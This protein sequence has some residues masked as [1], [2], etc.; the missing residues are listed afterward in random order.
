MVESSLKKVENPQGKSEVGQACYFFVCLLSPR[1]SDGTVEDMRKGGRW[2]KPPIQPTFFLRI[3][4]CHCDRIHSFLIDVHCFH[5][6]YVRKQPMA[7]KE[8]CAEHWLKKNFRTAWIVALA[9]AIQLNNVENSIKHLT[10]KNF[11]LDWSK[12]LLGGYDLTLPKT[13]PCFYVSAVQVF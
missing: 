12:T 2:F 10:I 5:N 4:D 11:N 3:D 1:N 13:G 6:G 8:Y 9:T 7:W